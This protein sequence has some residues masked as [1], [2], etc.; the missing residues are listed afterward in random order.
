MDANEYS[1]T[2]VKAVGLSFDMFADEDPNEEELR[3]FLTSVDDKLKSLGL[4]SVAE[5]RGV[6]E[7]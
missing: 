1:D 3:T 4:K 2:G 7:A 5:L 6:D